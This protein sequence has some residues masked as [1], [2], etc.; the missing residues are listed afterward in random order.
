MADL[1]RGRDERT[2]FLTV[3]DACLPGFVRAGDRKFFRTVAIAVYEG[4]EGAGTTELT[5]DYFSLRS[6]VSRSMVRTRITRI[7][8]SLQV[9]GLQGLML[10]S[11]LI[12]AMIRAGIDDQ[13]ILQVVGQAQ[14]MEQLHVRRRLWY[15]SDFPT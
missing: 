10:F 9:S 2:H 11:K 8:E 15:E 6:D 5:P 4:L 14:L 7:A 1:S 13:T 12:L 3:I